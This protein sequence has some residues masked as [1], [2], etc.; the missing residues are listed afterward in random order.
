[1]GD[2]APYN[3]IKNNSLDVG[4]AESTGYPVSEVE[5]WLEELIDKNIEAYN[6]QH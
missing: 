1:M 6:L 2:V 3:G 5:S 4:K